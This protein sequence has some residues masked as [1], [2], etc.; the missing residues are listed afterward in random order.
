MGWL[1]YDYSHPQS[2]QGRPA[3][4]PLQL[5]QRLPG[6]V[7]GQDLQRLP[8]DAGHRQ[9]HPGAAADRR[10]RP[11][12]AGERGA[13]SRSR[14]TQP[15]SRPGA[16]QR[17]GRPS[18]ARCCC[19]TAAA[20][21]SGVRVTTTIGGA[22]VTVTTDGNGAYRFSP[23]IPQ[24]NHRAAR[25]RPGH[26]PAVAG[27]RLG[28]G[29]RRGEQDHRPARPRQPAGDGAQRRRHAGPGRRGER[30][31]QRLPQRSGERRQ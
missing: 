24:G 1:V 22:D 7:R 30:Q 8:A 23:I 19:P 12:A 5:R 4:R 14:P 17:H 28:A 20:A 18:P 2:D 10:S 16:G 13:G 6:P 3:D 15:R 29:R 9:R 25:L 26:H 27:E 31:R 11:G 21:G